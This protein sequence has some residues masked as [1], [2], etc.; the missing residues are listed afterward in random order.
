MGFTL[1]CQLP[2]NILKRWQIYSTR[3]NPFLRG[4]RFYT[5]VEARAFDFGNEKSYLLSILME[6]NNILWLDLLQY[7]LFQKY[8]ISALFWNES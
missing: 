1:C 2:K 3:Y 4:I 7:S 8:G 5:V 6:F